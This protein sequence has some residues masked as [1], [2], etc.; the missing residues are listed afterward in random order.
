MRGFESTSSNEVPS[1]IPNVTSSWALDPNSGTRLAWD[2]VSFTLVMYDMVTIPLLLFPLS[3]Q[4]F[5]VMAWFAR[6]FWSLDIPLT[7]C[8]SYVTFSG[9]IESTGRG[10]ARRYLRTWFLLDFAIV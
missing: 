2:L 5:N 10:I 3:S 4:F 9:R 7:F 1:A 6:M 8:S